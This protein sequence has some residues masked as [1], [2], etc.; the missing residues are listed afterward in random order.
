MAKSRAQGVSKPVEASSGWKPAIPD[1]EVLEELGSGVRGTVWRASDGKKTLALKLLRKG[2]RVDR[3]ALE[4][5]LKGTP[6]R[7]RH[8]NLAPVE[9][10]GELGDGAFFYASP[11]LL[12]DSLERLNADRRRQK[13]DQ[14]SLCP[15]A[16]GTDGE[17]HPDL[18]RRATDLFAELAD[19]LALAHREGLVHRRLSPKNLILTPA[20]RLVVTDFG[21]DACSDAGD[22][23]VY[24]APEQLEPFPENVGP[25]ADV[26]AL[27]VLLYEVLT[28]RVPFEAESPRAL[29]ARIQ[30]GRAARPRSLDARISTGLEACILK[31]MAVDPAERYESCEALA[32]DLRRAAKSVM[33]AAEEAA[34]RAPVK[35]PGRVATSILLRG[36]LALALAS[37]VGVSFWIGQ[38][39]HA[40]REA[41]RAAK[42]GGAPAAATA[43]AVDPGSPGAATGVE[44]L[45]PLRASDSEKHDGLGGN[46]GEPHGRA[47]VIVERPATTVSAAAPSLDRPAAMRTEL[48]EAELASTD[49]AVQARALA[50]LAL[51]LRSGDRPPSDALLAA[52]CLGGSATVRKQAI[53]T[54]A[55]SGA[56]GP[57]LRLL[58]FGDEDR[59]VELE[60]GAFAALHDSLRAIADEDAR[61]ALCL[62]GW[63]T[64]GTL[65]LA[66]APASLWLDPNLVI[67]VTERE[68]REF[69]ARWVRAMAEVDPDR[70]L[71]A[72]PR[73]ADREEAVGDLI[74]ALER[75]PTA[76][77]RDMIV[78][79]VREHGFSAGPA[80]LS[81]LA[82]R[83][84][85]EELLGLAR[86]NLP[87]DLRAAALE[88]L[89]RRF[90]GLHVPELKL[91][92]LGSPEPELRRIA[93]RHIAA[94]DEPE[95]VLAIPRALEDPE[96]R[97]AAL[98]W[99]QRVP[100]DV[101]APACLELLGSSDSEARHAAR[102][103]L[104][105]SRRQDLVFD[106]T[107]RLLSSNGET[108][109]AAYA[110][111]AARGELTRIP[112]QLAV[113]F[114]SPT[115]LLE[116]GA[117]VQE[118]LRL[119]EVAEYFA[120]SVR[121]VWT[122]SGAAA[123]MLGSRVWPAFAR[124]P[125][126]QPS[127]R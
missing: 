77:A 121:R 37:L 107:Q 72:A 27:G 61:L 67:D 117:S 89:G 63:E 123:G 11:L 47:A 97:S 102:E 52:R 79:L 31:A 104:S 57:L 82:R 32:A 80:A 75:T 112:G 18:A 103:R 19:G 28:S 48:L 98:E 12:G 54:L 106:L 119:L 114:G 24:R 73:I 65:D 4:R 66:P 68:P 14:P 111:F 9:L 87:L 91:I 59:C 118:V 49:S 46:A 38:R 30:E 64:F 25:P 3:R 26:Y 105:L 15:L 6:G 100:P 2:I 113:V 85:D 62:W 43:T 95:S 21:G 10:L 60:G 88:L 124:M 23:L 34:A 84:G 83:D 20:G 122:A 1:I 17:T 109:A 86:S 13:C 41:S 110:V 76:G 42:D 33:T 39:N 120:A 70:L 44:S 116:A 55:L 126:T 53:E 92:A 7:I 5:L 71:E 36:A 69:T 125:E 94:F 45:I 16:V 40:A 8:P 22:D 93:F 35:R 29:K 108:R 50:R 101:G 96:L 58:S 115:R 81:A 74:A 51:D 56:S 90:A 78:R 127:S 99:L